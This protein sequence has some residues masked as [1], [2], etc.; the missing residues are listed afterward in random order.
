MID[1]DKI[2]VYTGSE[3]GYINGNWYYWNGSSWT[4]GGVYNSVAIN[5]DAVP[6]QGSNN[7]V[8][9]GGVYS[10]L[11]GKV[12]AETGKG[13]STNDYSDAE[14]QKVTDATADL[15]AMTTA[16]AEDVG[17]ALKAK[18]V[19]NGKVTEWEFGEAGG[20]IDL[21]NTLT[22]PTKPAQAKATGDR[23]SAIEN[24]DVSDL[25]SGVT[26]EI[27]SI[28]GGADVSNGNRLRTIGY[29]P[30]PE[31]AESISFT[32]TNGAQMAVLSFS[33]QSAGGFVDTTGWQSGTGGVYVYTIPSN[34]AYIRL[35]LA[36]ANNANFSDTTFAENISSV[37][38]T[39]V[40]STIKNINERIDNVYL[41]SE[42]Y[43]KAEVAELTSIVDFDLLDGVTWEFGNLSRDS[44]AEESS[45][46]VIRTP[47]ISILTSNTWLDMLINDGNYRVFFYNAEHS[48]ITD[49][50][51]YTG[52]DMGWFHEDIT[53]HKVPE[54]TVYVR[55][56]IKDATAVTDASRLSVT[57]HSII[58]EIN[59]EAEQDIGEAV[60]FEY[61]VYYGSTGITESQIEAQTFVFIDALRHGKRALV[62]LKAGNIL[63]LHGIGLSGTR[64][65]YKVFDASTGVMIDN[66][67]ASTT[68]GT[69]YLRYNVD[70][71]VYISAKLGS[72]FFARVIKPSSLAYDL[73]KSMPGAGTPIIDFNDA[74]SVIY[75]LKGLT[76]KHYQGRNPAVFVHFSDIHGDVA[77]T[78][79]I[80][81]FVT[82]SR[83]SGYINDT[84]CT[85]DIVAGYVTDANPFDSVS[86]A[87]NIICVPGN[88]D[89]AKGSDYATLQEVYEKLY[90]GKIGNWGVTQPESGASSYL[91]YFYKDYSTQ[92]LR[93]IFLDSNH[94]SA[95]ITAQAS[96]LADILESARTASLSVI[97]VSHYFFDISTLKYVDCGF[98]PGYRVLEGAFAR[99]NDAFV[100][101]V[102]T[103][104]TNGGDF[105]CWLGGHSHQDYVITNDAGTQLEVGISC[106]T[107]E[108]GR[109]TGD[110]IREVGTKS[111]DCINVLSIDTYCKR[112]SILRLG[113]DRSR[114]MVSKK[115]LC[116]DYANRAVVW[117]D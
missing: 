100:S 69:Y 99:I 34:V 16:T 104:I 35:V 85:G 62:H 88:H 75:A 105:V 56:T 13:L 40:V 66:L 50:I 27:G 89:C 101:A 52:S 41:K 81:D 116:L 63:R 59:A 7:A 22:D 42:T 37:K 72:N 68:E 76:R 32:L 24:L 112:I 12:D 33:S 2:Y 108:A 23:L 58:G 117:S 51:S 1:T 97:C 61:G 49:A 45:S 14:K 102:E 44:G 28:S 114:L 29:I 30:V 78:Q 103:F 10:A 113:V 4:S 73:T 82:D 84:I 36:T 38:S 79:R 60:P 26:W 111:Q 48:R 109:V 80:V 19:T 17:K 96:W 46:T 107:K 53:S 39:T 98:T 87:E 11:A 43:S 57:A 67:T 54:G 77:N 115:H 93:V 91:G 31:G 5:I 9:S 95:Y 21:D 71:N 15:A 55:F 92:K 25:L 20:N 86:G 64:Q 94:D 18:T 8:R 65:L 6:T 106:A 70:V 3:T 90:T 74:D 47:Y 83:V 110:E